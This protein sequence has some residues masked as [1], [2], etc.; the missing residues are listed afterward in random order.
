MKKNKKLIGFVCGC[1]GI[2]LLV[3][4]GFIVVD[5]F[6]QTLSDSIARD[7]TPWYGE[8]QDTL[9]SQSN[10]RGSIVRNYRFD[11]HGAAVGDTEI[12]PD[13]PAGIMVVGGVIDVHAAMLPTNGTCG[14]EIGTADILATGSTLEAVGAKAIVPVWTVGSSVITANSTSPVILDVAGTAYTS[15]VFTVVLDVIQLNP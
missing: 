7:V 4:S 8:N 10:R 6:S 1:A 15:G 5:A 2:A 12:G 3:L 11:V 13:L 14:I 9:P